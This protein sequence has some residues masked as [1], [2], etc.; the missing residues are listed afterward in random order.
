MSTLLALTI[1]AATSALVLGNIRI[2]ASDT[3]RALA[4][5]TSRAR[6]SGTLGPKLAFAGLWLLIFLL[7][8][9]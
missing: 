4:N 5:A 6:A 2:V 3:F 7:G 1:L 9:F 8:Y